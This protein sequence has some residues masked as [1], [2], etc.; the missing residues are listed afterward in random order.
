MP[1]AVS[2]LYQASRFFEIAAGDRNESLE[3]TV[4]T[5]YFNWTNR[6]QAHRGYEKPELI[7]GGWMKVWAD[8]LVGPRPPLNVMRARSIDAQPLQPTR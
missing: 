5:A 7:H 8:H 3:D 1:Y 2:E 4:V 6:N